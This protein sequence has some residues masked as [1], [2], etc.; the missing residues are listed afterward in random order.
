MK[1][2]GVIVLVAGLVTITGVLLLDRLTNPASAP[3]NWSALPAAVRAYTQAVQARG[4]ALPGSVT[5]TQLVQ[6]GF[7]AP[8]AAKTFDG[9]ELT[10]SLRTNATE[11]QAYVVLARLAN[12]EQLAVMGDGSVQSLGHGR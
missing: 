9:V 6:G 11:P 2:L 7:L 12:G 1:R 8:E 3:Q 10:F 5:L 4:D